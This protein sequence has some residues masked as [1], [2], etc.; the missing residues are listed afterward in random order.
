MDVLSFDSSKLE[1]A[2]L[3]FAKV[4]DPENYYLVCE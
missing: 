4:V 3:A 1:F 2:K